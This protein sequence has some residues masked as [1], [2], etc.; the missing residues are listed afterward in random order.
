MRR[1]GRLSR[2]FVCAF[3]QF[4]VLAGVPMRPEQISEL[5]QMLQRPKLAHVDPERSERDGPP[6]PSRRSGGD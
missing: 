6:E 1:P 4:G 3:L 5:M 2:L